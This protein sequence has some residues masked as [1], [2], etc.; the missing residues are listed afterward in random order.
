VQRLLD[1]TLATGALVAIF[2]LLAVAA[3]I[4]RCTGE[5]DVFYMQDRVGRNGNIFKL[6]KF[7]TMLRDSPKLGA[8]AVTL[9]DDP[10]VLPFGRFLRRSKI[11]ELPQLWNVLVGDM[12][13]VGPRPMV[14]KTFA[15]YPAESQ[16][17]LSSVRPGLSGVGSII[18]R[19][20]ESLLGGSDNPISFYSKVVN[21][22][23]AELECWY[24]E[25]QGLRTYIEVISL[26]MW[27][28]MFKKTKL[29][30]RIWQSLPT[31]PGDLIDRG[32]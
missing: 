19:D 21:P 28:V 2:P 23:K 13:L 3:V 5:G 15:A 7:A 17:I 25:H 26:T 27:A 1:V 29:P 9:K 6:L 30:W 4:L 10:R 8:G 24:V 31:P 14:P 22:Y 32:L 12:S 11:N 16:P 20:E 18:F